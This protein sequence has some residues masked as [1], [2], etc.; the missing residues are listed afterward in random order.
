MTVACYTPETC[1]WLNSGVLEFFDVYKTFYF[2][3]DIMARPVV[4]ILD[5]LDYVCEEDCVSLTLRLCK[6]RGCEVAVSTV[7]SL[8]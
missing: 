2:M 1:K 4:L 6:H 3:R 8:T 5:M 7:T